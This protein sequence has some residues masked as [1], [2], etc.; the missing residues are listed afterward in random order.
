MNTPLHLHAHAMYCNFLVVKKMKICDI[1]L[2]F[3]QNID[4]GYLLQLYHCGSDE[5]P[6]SK[7]P[8]SVLSNKE[9]KLH[10]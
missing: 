6:R 10:P 3:A 9:N 8:Q 2:V 4:L 5:Y 7:Y 1:F